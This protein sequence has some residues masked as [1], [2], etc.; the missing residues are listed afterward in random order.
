MY[1]R[2]SVLISHPKF[3]VN[4]PV[5]PI[6]LMEVLPPPRRPNLLRAHP[7]A[8]KARQGEEGFIGVTLDGRTST[9][10]PLRLDHLIRMTDAT[11]IFQHARYNVPDYHH[12][13]CTE[14][15]DRNDLGLP[16]Y[17]ARTGGCRDDLHRDRLNQNQGAESSLAFLLSLAEMSPLAHPWTISHP[18]RPSW[19]KIVHP[20]A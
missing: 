9:L 17:D 6:K 5:S 8:S 10:P 3:C 11:G 4:M 13:Y 2:L 7:P 19:F 12:G 18:P 20:R 14:A 16:L 15:M 1:D